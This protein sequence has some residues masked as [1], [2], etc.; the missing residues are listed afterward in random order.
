MIKTRRFILA[1]LL[2]AVLALGLSAAAYAED[3]VEASG[4]CGD[5]VTWTLYGDGRLVISGTGAMKEF[6]CANDVPWY[7]SR[8]SVKS[9]EIG[10]GV[11][12]IAGSATSNVVTLTVK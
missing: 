12:N 6:S 4:S 2:C 9:A 8:S 3:G 1:L 11:T 10:S 7:N 5:N